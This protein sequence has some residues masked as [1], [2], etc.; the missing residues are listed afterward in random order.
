MKNPCVAFSILILDPGLIARVLS[1]PSSV[2]TSI[3]SNSN[4]NLEKH[5]LKIENKR[6]C[7]KHRQRIYLKQS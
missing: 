4:S 3:A 6:L 1:L 5:N 2:R 7:S